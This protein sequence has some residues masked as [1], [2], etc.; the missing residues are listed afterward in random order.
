MAASKEFDAKC[1]VSPMAGPSTTHQLRLLLI[2]RLFAV[3]TDNFF[4]CNKIF[5][6]LF[7]YL[8]SYFLHCCNANLHRPSKGEYTCR[9]RSESHASKPAEVPSSNS[10][11]C[12]VTVP[13]IGQKLYTTL[14]NHARL[15]LH[16]PPTNLAIGRV[17]CKCR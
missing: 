7:L 5:K 12:A 8:I 17:L 4:D 13:P 16:A 2:S 10:L 14:A 3:A 11:G 9:A 15:N 6:F 1:H